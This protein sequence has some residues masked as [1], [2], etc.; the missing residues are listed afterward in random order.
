MYVCIV[1][2]KGR[3]SKAFLPDTKRFNTEGDR[4]GAP[5]FHLN[6]CFWREREKKSPLRD[7]TES[8]KEKNRTQDDRIQF[9]WTTGRW[10]Q[11]RK[12]KT[13]ARRITTT[14]FLIVS[15]E[16]YLEHKHT[17]NKL[18]TLRANILASI[19]KNSDQ[20]LSM[21]F[22]EYLVRAYRKRLDDK[23]WVHILIVSHS[24]IISGPR[25][26]C[27][28]ECLKYWRI[29]W[30]HSRIIVPNSSQNSTKSKKCVGEFKCHTQFG[31][32]SVRQWTI[33]FFRH[34]HVCA[35]HAEALDP[36]CI[37]AYTVYF[38]DAKANTWSIIW[39][40]NDTIS[41]SNYVTAWYIVMHA[42]TLSMIPNV[43]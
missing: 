37:H 30:L 39:K 8:T 14:A 32:W 11:N 26:Y 2:Q 22:M 33:S 13:I 15:S 9:E 7:W 35:T 19:S 38:L 34:C 17:R 1:C 6:F 10:L 12:K 36:K 21:S 40:Q 5:E 23:R 25:T 24:R 42:E 41:P 29:W 18:W 3:M 16:N 43:M 28:S 4:I 27:A 31:S 20:M